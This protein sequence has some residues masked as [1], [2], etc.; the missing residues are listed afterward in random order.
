MSTPIPSVLFDRSGTVYR[1]GTG[2]ATYGRNLAAAARLC[3]FETETL[4]SS[5]VAVDTRNPVLAQ[6]QLA[7]ARREPMLPWLDDVRDAIAGAVRAPFGHRP[8][9]LPPADVVLGRSGQDS[10]AGRT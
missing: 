3:G 10:A 5:D 6:V 9:L 4:L 8:R 1:M 2:I 7:D